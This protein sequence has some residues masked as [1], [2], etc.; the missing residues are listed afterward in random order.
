MTKHLLREFI[1]QSLLIEGPLDKMR[2]MG[3]P[4][5]VGEWIIDF[6]PEYSKK[7]AIWYAKEFSEAFHQFKDYLKQYRTAKKKKKDP[8]FI[9]LLFQKLIDVISNTEKD[10]EVIDKWA[11]ST[12]A[13]LSSKKNT[14]VVVGSRYSA[15]LESVP[16][17]FASAARTAKQYFDIQEGSTFM[18]F[19][20]GWSWLNRETNYCSIEGRMMGHCG[21]SENEDSVLFSLRDPKGFPRVTAEILIDDDGATI[22]QMKGKQNTVP[23][24]KYWPKIFDLLKSPNIKLKNYHATGVGDYGKDLLWEMIPEEIRDEIRE[25]NH[26]SFLEEEAKD[27]EA[28]LNAAEVA[29]ED[30]MSGFEHDVLGVW[31]DT[32]SWEEIDEQ[33]AWIGVSVSGYVSLDEETVKIL[34]KANKGERSVRWRSPGNELV[35][36]ILRKH[37]DLPAIEVHLDGND[38][39]FYIEDGDLSSTVSVDDPEVDAFIQDF[40]YYETNAIT[41][42]D[43]IK[44][45]RNTLVSH[46]YIESQQEQRA[47]ELDGALTNVDITMEDDPTD[48]DFH[49]IFASVNIFNGKNLP[50]LD[51]QKIKGLL[52]TDFVQKFFSRLTDKFSP[53]LQQLILPNVELGPMKP[54]ATP[55][56]ATLDTDHYSNVVMKVSFHEDEPAFEDAI[57]F[58]YAIDNHIDSVEEMFAEMIQIALN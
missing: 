41:S 16:F 15:K 46:G 1:S 12:K 25:V 48:D 54:F 32:S 49:V 36:E 39:R 11:E 33:T 19:P 38:I 34:E 3:V 22:H 37:F 8:E 40:M 52:K 14:E 35:E 31:A 6:L 56:S 9:S 4:E 24:K 13:N 55:A 42:E 2:N 10:V 47:E 43:F 57:E 17:N 7:H 5:E 26:E 58:I 51:Y 53:S 23:E 44:I 20:D 27:I 21:M 30:A 28:I 29:V 45:L 50:L 18:T